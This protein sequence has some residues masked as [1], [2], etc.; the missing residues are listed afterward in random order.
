MTPTTDAANALPTI[1]AREVPL[2]RPLHWLA[3]GW[4]DLRRSGWPSLVHG[5]IVALG[6]L[7]I[8]ALAT[9]HWQLL[10]GAFSAFLLVGPLLA[11]GLY[12]LSRRLEQGERAG[13]GEVLAAWRCGCRPF[14]L[15]GLMLVAFGT[16]W[17]VLSATLFHFFV[18]EPITGTHAF[19]RYAVAQPDHL[20]V[21][22]TVL[23]GLVAAVVF[24]ATVVSL[25]L[26]LDRRV[27]FDVSLRASV[28]A[29]TANPAPMGLWALLIMAAVGLSM[30]TL[31]LGFVVAIP[32][33]G[34]A[35]WHAYR[36]TLDP[37]DIPVRT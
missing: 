8:L 15:M 5:L 30:A 29:V 4:R 35:T 31:M 33:I 36:D 7:L 27:P 22:W 6:G 2:T 18:T 34:H 26:M 17:V 12:A 20:F 11:T 14:V 32:V 21:L 23:G 37:G 28:D 25:P 13:F 19:L 24:A 1:A 9:R 10:P 3:L 16:V